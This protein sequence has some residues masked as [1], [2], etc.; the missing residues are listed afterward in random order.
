MTI[1]QNRVINSEHSEERGTGQ[2]GGGALAPSGKG[3]AVMRSSRAGVLRAAILGAAILAVLIGGGAQARSILFVGNSFTYGGY[4]PAQYYRSGTVTDLN[5]PDRSGRTFGGVPAIFKAFTVQAGLD[6]R[7]SL[8]TE[9]S[10]GLDFH[11]RRRLPVLDKPWDEVVLQSFSTLDAVRPGD[12]GLLKRYTALLVDTLLARNPKARIWLDAT[13]S[14][15]DL[16]YQPRKRWSGRPIQQMAK[17]I[18]SGYGQAL[19][20]SPRAAGVI[21]TGLAFNRAI[22]EGLADPNPYDG[23]A[24]GQIDLWAFDGQHASAY[25]YYL[26]ALMVF[27]RVTGKDPLS[28]GEHEQAAADFHF[29]PAQT[30]ALQQ[31][32]HDQLAAGF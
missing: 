14:R 31:I 28:L 8:E 13:W 25:G 11:Y 10:T 9:A 23:I 26:Q 18:A 15:A 5:G 21:Q 4:S 19:R 2:D 30:H 12:P 1:P 27:G 3:P 24:P 29:S 16:T 20:A 17:D 32:A 22:D 6:Y 7:V